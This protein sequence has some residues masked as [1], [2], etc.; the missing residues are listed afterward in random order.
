YV[1][2]FTHIYQLKLIPPTG[3]NKYECTDCNLVVTEMV[4]ENYSNLDLLSIPINAIIKGV[5]AH[6]YS[7]QLR[8]TKVVIV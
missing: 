3:S 7:G 1:Q 2:L 6:N 5:Q 8:Q 4:L